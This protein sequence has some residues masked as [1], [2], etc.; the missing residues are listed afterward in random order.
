MSAIVLPYSLANDVVADADQLQAMF[1]A[2]V[3]GLSSAGNADIRAD[4]AISTSKLAER[5]SDHED[6]VNCVPYSNDVELD[7]TPVRYNLDTTF[8]TVARR[9]LKL[10]SGQLGYIVGLDV[11][12]LALDNTGGTARLNILLDGIQLGNSYQDLTAVGFYEL[13]NAGGSDDPFAPFNNDS[14]L[15]FQV[16]ASAD[17]PSIAGLDV[18]V[19][20]KK[21]FLP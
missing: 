3:A 21:S 10:R 18:T 12:L 14:V 8:R 4:A 7:G 20:T 13:V 15:E 19:R 11:S 17:G 2:L 6:T 5:Y 9:R 1:D 16:G